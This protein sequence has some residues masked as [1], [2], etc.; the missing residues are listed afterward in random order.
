M[1]L[2][3]LYCSLSVGVLKNLAMSNDGDGT[4]AEKHKKSVLLASNQGLKRLYSRF[5]LSE[6]YVIIQQQEGR[7][8]YHLRKQFSVSGHDP[9]VIDVPYVMDSLNEPFQEDVI[10][11]FSITDHYGCPVPLND[12][13]K[14]HSA[15]TPKPETVQYDYPVAGE[16]LMLT[17]QAS[18][19]VLCYFSGDED[20]EDVEV[21]Y[22]LNNETA[23]V[24]LL[25]E[26]LH[27]AL[28]AY[29]GYFV[30]NGINTAES[31][32]IAAEHKATYE[33]LCTVFENRDLGSESTSKTNTK[34]HERGFC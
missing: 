28:F 13:G 3:E 31:K 34:F 21:N 22:D 6:K 29:I 33:E 16:P 5:M 8:F 18:H 9:N 2:E 27:E 30:Y 17:Y 11:I 1:N 25:P 12:S 7:T 23:N 24:I 15:Y 19:P 26:T 32:G 4:I 20:N 10:R 14:V